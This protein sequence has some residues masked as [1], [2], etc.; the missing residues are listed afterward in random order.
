MYVVPPEK[1]QFYRNNGW[2]V[3]EDVVPPEEIQRIRSVLT[4]ILSGRIDSKGNR[5]DLGSHVDRVQSTSENI[6]QIAWPTDLTSLLDENTLV[7]VSRA[8]SDAL[9]GDSPGTWAMDCNQFLVKNPLTVTDTPLHQDQSYYVPL[10]DPRGCNLWLALVDVTEPMGCLWFEKCPLETPLPLRQH[11]PAGRGGGALEC[12]NGPDFSVM[13]AAPLRAGSL[14]VH[15]HMT[16]HYARGN[17]T[18]TPREAYVVQTRPSVSVRHARTLGFDH[19]RIKGNTPRAVNNSEG[20]SK[21]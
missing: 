13:T 12:G 1:I 16:P 17:I 8:I 14:T 15:S 21:L 3:L 20:G 18:N 6:V 19:G 4:D 9:Y 2:V 11:R 7:M 10:P 5:A